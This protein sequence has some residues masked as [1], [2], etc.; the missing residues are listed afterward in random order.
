MAELLAASYTR[1]AEAIGHYL[2]DGAHVVA[3]VPMIEYGSR[4]ALAIVLVDGTVTKVNRMDFDLSLREHAIGARAIDLL[5]EQ[6][7]DWGF[8]KPE[9]CGTSTEEWKVSTTVTDGGRGRLTLAVDGSRAV[10]VSSRGDDN[11]A[12]MVGPVRPANVVDVID[13]YGPRPAC[14]RC[15][16]DDCSRPVSEVRRV[17]E[18]ARRMK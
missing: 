18:I 11:I 1:R 16:Q 6:R 2:I 3:F 4:P 14:D 9:E 15:H 12:Y 8:A 7:I 5:D 17:I 10:A 13:W